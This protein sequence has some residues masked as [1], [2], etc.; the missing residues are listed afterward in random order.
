MLLLPLLAQSMQMSH[1]LLVVTNA[2]YVSSAREWTW[3]HDV[4]AAPKH[5]V[6]HFADIYMA[7]VYGTQTKKLH[8]YRCAASQSL[9]LLVKFSIHVGDSIPVV[10]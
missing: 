10:S 8:L 7:N 4:L 6:E 5:M 3:M 2:K 1:D 9:N